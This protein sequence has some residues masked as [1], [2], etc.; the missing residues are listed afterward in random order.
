MTDLLQSI[1]ANMCLCRIRLLFTILCILNTKH[2][3]FSTFVRYLFGVLKTG[4]N[5]NQNKCTWIYLLLNKFSLGSGLINCCWLS[6]STEID[7]LCI[8]FVFFFY[9]KRSENC[10]VLF[11]ISSYYLVYILATHASAK[12]SIYYDFFS[13]SPKVIQSIFF[14]YPFCRM[15]RA[16]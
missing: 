16:V 14:N 5:G 13:F 12:K 15:L 9:T 2:S 6:F 1:S 11:S 3:P 10:F 7:Y 8:F 4:V